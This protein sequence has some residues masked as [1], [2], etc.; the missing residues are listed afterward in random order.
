MNIVYLLFAA[1]YMV[2]FGVLSYN[3][4]GEKLKGKP[5]ESDAS[6]IIDESQDEYPENGLRLFA[7]M[8]D[9]A[10]SPSDNITHFS[11]EYSFPHCLSTYHHCTGTICCNLYSR[12]PPS[13]S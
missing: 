4:I 6:V 5:A 3:K 8:D 9:Y 11:L 10:L 7:D 12:P 2:S 13:I 1:V